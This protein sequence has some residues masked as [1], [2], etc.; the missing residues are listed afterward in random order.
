MAKVEL[1]GNQV[2]GPI[3]PITLPSARRDN[4]PPAG[5]RRVFTHAAAGSAVP[6]CSCRPEFRPNTRGK[7]QHFLGCRQ[8]LESVE[9]KSA[10]L[11]VS[12]PALA[13]ARSRPM[14]GIDA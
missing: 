14:C 3:I 7:V 13:L 9:L 2:V 12:K 6:V 8:S 11:E 4:R 1:S 5:T 10:A